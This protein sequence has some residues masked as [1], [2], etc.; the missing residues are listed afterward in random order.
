MNQFSHVCYQSSPLVSRQAP[1]ILVRCF[2]HPHHRPFLPPELPGGSLHLSLSPHFGTDE[3]HTSSHLVLG[4]SLYK[5]N[6]LVVRP[7]VKPPAAGCRDRFF[8]S[9]RSFEK[10]FAK[11]QGPEKE[12]EEK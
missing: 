1:D 11:S 5:L 2:V 12:P 9:R 8:L 6:A 7:N 4:T 10:A 3:N